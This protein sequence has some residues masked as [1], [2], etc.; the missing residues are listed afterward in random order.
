MNRVV[1]AGKY[2][3]FGVV[4]VLVAL[5]SSLPAGLSAAAAPGL[6][7]SEVH[8]AGSG[9]GTYGADWFEVTNT[10]TSAVDIT[11]WKMDD[12]SNSFDLSV[13]LNGVGS[14]A[15]GQS[16]VFIDTSAPIDISAFG[17]AWF[18]SNVPGGFTIGTY[19]G[20]GVG[21]STGGD[22]VYIFDAAGVAQTGIS[23]GTADALAPF[24]TFDNAAGL[25]GVAISQLSAVGVNGAGVALN[26]VVEIG[27]PGRIAP[28]PEP[29]TY[30]LLLAGLG[31]V[32][33][34]A[35]KRQA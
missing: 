9:N 29:T 24:Q 31:L 2:L 23:F 5:S 32:G 21:L 12:G 35:R 25:N 7:I 8:P 11:G 13:A 27:S 6:V 10:G 1:N 22:A 19:G 3:G 4:T 17:T 30:A 20:A 34:A 14:I 28:V 18:G 15:P 26:S 16:V 33:V